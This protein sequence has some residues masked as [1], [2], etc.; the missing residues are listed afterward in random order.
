MPPEVDIASF[1]EA[2][3]HKTAAPEGLHEV[4]GAAAMAVAACA[5]VNAEEVP[6][7]PE[8]RSLVPSAQILA[9]NCQGGGS[10]FVDL[11]PII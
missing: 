2:V 5:G 3:P 4:S 1:P 11:T 7:A 9:I 10:L 6:V 8:A